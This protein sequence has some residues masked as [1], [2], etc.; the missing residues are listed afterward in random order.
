MNRRAARFPRRPLLATTAAAAIAACGP[1]GE[2]KASDTPPAG[3]D[4]KDLIVAIPF[5]RTDQMTH[6]ANRLAV[7]APNAF[8]YERLIHLDESYQLKPGL[9]ERWELLPDGR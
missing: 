3:G 6:D 5:I 1:T 9:A 4:L 7:N 8:I 2:Q